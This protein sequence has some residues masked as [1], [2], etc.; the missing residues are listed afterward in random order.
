M[1]QSLKVVVHMTPGQNGVT[2]SCIGVVVHGKGRSS[3][4][5]LSGW[6]GSIKLDARVIGGPPG[7]G[8]RRWPTILVRAMK[9]LCQPTELQGESL[10]LV[11]A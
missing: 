2:R 9:D 1:C 8:L 11:E 5:I 10:P 4:C 7:S 3:T 6:H